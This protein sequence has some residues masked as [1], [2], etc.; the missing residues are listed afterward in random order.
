MCSMTPERVRL[1]V[2][3]T[4]EL[5]HEGPRSWSSDGLEPPPPEPTEYDLLPPYGTVYNFAGFRVLWISHT[6]DDL[7]MDALRG[8][9]NADARTL[10]NMITD[11][12]RMRPVH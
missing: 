4:D 3:G 6:L 7:M 2:E 5:L 8:Q 11:G 12:I 10:Y 1:T 9:M